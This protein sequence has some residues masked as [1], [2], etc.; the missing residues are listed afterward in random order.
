MSIDEPGQNPAALVTN[1]V[2]DS[3]GLGADLGDMAIIADAEHGAGGYLTVNDRTGPQKRTA[4][5]LHG[6]KFSVGDH[7]GSNNVRFAVGLGC[8]QKSGQG[9]SAGGPAGSFSKQSRPVL[10]PVF[11]TRKFGYTCGLENGSVLSRL[12]GM[13]VRLQIDRRTAGLALMLT[14]IGK[15]PVKIM[16]VGCGQ[17]VLDAPDFAEHFIGGSSFRLRRWNFGFHW[18][19]GRATK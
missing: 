5:R 13:S 14:R 6:R 1:F 2:A 15:E 11:G 9:E 3:R 12:L 16:A 4:K 7:T 18:S 10:R 19:A 8:A 17:F